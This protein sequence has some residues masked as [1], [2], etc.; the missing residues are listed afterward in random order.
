MLPLLLKFSIVGASQYEQVQ[1]LPDEI[2][3]RLFL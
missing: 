2:K 1:V 3:S